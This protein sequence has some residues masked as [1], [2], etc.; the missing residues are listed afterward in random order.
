MTFHEEQTDTM[1][2]SVTELNNKRDHVAE[3]FLKEDGYIW[4]A[5]LRYTRVPRKSLIIRDTYAYKCKSHRPYKLGQSYDDSVTACVYHLYN[6]VCSL[7]GIDPIELYNSVY[8][9]H[10]FTQAQFDAILAFADWQG[11]LTVMDWSQ[12]KIDMV[13]EGL[14]SV[15]MYQL[16]NELCAKVPV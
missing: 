6:Q 4:Y 3:V 10:I 9:D 15:N 2:L 13:I 1:Y 5:V 16:A 7:F 12:D 14:H 8:P 11:C